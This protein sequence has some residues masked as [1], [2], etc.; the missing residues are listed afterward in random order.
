MS[1]SPL[2]SIIAVTLLTSLV[3]IGV[4]AVPPLANL[5]TSIGL[6]WLFNLRG[7]REPPPEVVVLGIGRESAR[8][9]NKP[10]NPRKWPRGLHAAVVDEL[11]RAQA[12][13][14]TFDLLFE[15]PKNAE[16]ERALAAAMERSANVILFQYLEREVL[17]TPEYQ[18]QLDV[19][20]M[21][22]P[23]PVLMQAAAGVAPFPLPSAR[24]RV[25]QVWT[26]KRGAGGVPTMPA[27]AM[28]QFAL[29]YWRT[30]LDSLRDLLPAEL[31]AGLIL[32]APGGA[33]PDTAML[34]ATTR[35]LFL[36]Q[37]G[38]A[39]Q[40]RERLGA[41]P[42]SRISPSARRALGGLLHLYAQPDSPILDHYGGPGTI[43]TIPYHLLVTDPD[44]V[45][46]R[47]RDRA[48]FI[49]YTEAV[50]QEQKDSFRT[51]F[52][53]PDSPVIGGVELAATAFA[54][55]LEQRTIKSLPRSL[56]LMLIPAWALLL[57]LVFLRFAGWLGVLLAAVLA[58][59]W[60]TAAMLLF[61]HQAVQIPVVGPLLFQLPT[62]LIASM[63]L[64]FVSVRDESRRMHDAFAHFVPERVVDELTANLGAVGTGSE[65]VYAVCMSTDVEQYTKIAERADPETLRNLLNRY[66]QVLFDPVR[67]HQGVIANV[68][69]DSMMALWTE[70]FANRRLFERATQAAVEIQ[71]DVRAY[72]AM[73]PEQP[74]TTRIGLHCGPVV[75]GHVGAGD[76]FE[77][78]PVGD[79]VNTA[80][81][82]ETLGKQLGVCTLASDDVVR[83][84]RFV[85]SRELGMFL[86]VGKRSALRVHELLGR[87]D[88]IDLGSRAL[89]EDFGHALNLFRDRQWATAN[90]LFE[91][92]LH[93]FPSDGPSLFYSDLCQRYR[94][95]PP[96]P[97]WGG[98]I[99]M[100]AK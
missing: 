50:Q 96:P 14:V 31:L 42:E 46:D 33:E 29:P 12:R 45:S 84:Q 44:R 98:I 13:V 19:Q 97:D 27:V 67:R 37:P 26:F 43:Q 64:R 7:T 6:H 62:A 10:Q 32:Y 61:T 47:L 58:M 90:A 95:D 1:P 3:G 38:L 100:R 93:R 57:G 52:T 8:A 21:R 65:S 53:R 69:G 17:P 91:D 76:R 55:L 63:S 74:F 24:S 79:I 16:Q 99:P 28:Q 86:L 66:Y 49:G 30:W 39:R 85:V 40:L 68:V 5:E 20:R 4:A 72:N 35:A 89:I 34:T 83:A 73:H 77:Y 9:L 18:L 48:I 22:N 41:V 54:N 92:L 25:D 82:I 60:T 11:R 81:R 59:T 87:Q 23:L 71:Q 78:R 15:E 94:H 80:S 36:S 2:R 56:R 51:V 75:L 70:R 88:D